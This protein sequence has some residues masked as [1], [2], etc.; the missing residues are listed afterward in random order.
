MTA[1]IFTAQIQDM[2]YPLLKVGQG[3]HMGLIMVSRQ[4]IQHQRI[5]ISGRLLRH[6]QRQLC[7]VRNAHQAPVVIRELLH[8]T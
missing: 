1:R 7:T 3:Q 8:Q 6:G 4:R 5:D 2:G